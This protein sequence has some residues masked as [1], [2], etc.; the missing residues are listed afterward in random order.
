MN[1]SYGI[2]H[3]QINYNDYLYHQLDGRYIEHKGYSI[4]ESGTKTEII[5]NL[6]IY[7]ELSQE[8]AT[9]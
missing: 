7:D 6:Q 3:L 9:Q 5:P 8:Q 2:T 4:H 1:P